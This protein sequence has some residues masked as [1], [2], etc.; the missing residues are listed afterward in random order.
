MWFY[1]H[2]LLSFFRKRGFHNEKT[3]DIFAT[4]IKDKFVP[5]GA[6]EGYYR[7]KEALSLGDAEKLSAAFQEFLLSSF[8]SFE[9][10]DEKNYQAM[11]LA[12]GALLFSDHVVKAEVNTG[13]GRCDILI[14]PKTSGGMG[15]VMEL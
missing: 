5:S 11:V 1:R 6:D 15:I 12:M 14:S 3:S 7:L 4:E 2:F 8:S 10:G 13:K 9:F